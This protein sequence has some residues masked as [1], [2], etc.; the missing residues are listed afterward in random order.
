[1]SNNIQGG[2]YMVSEEELK[3]IN[4]QISEAHAMIDHFIV[5]NNM[6]EVSYW[7]RMLHNLKL[8]K[9]RVLNT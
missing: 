8:H 6:T 3:N 4:I 1:M 5:L 7:R 2:H 9:R